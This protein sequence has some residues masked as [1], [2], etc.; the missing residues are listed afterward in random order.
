MDLFRLTPYHAFAS[1]LHTDTS[2][3]P[4]PVV[5]VYFVVVIKTAA[6]S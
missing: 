2:I 5:L 6:D 3:E 4:N 1:L